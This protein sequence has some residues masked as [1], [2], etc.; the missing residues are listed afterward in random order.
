MT[1]SRTTTL[2]AA[3]IA[4]VTAIGAVDA[5]IG[6]EWDLFAVLVIALGLGLV[7]VARL[8]LHRPAIPVRR[9]LVTWLRRRSDVSGESIGV[10]TDRALSAYQARYGQAPDPNESIRS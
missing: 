7:L 10:L 9:D 1:P 6:G 3:G 2:I 4:V 5:A 8:E